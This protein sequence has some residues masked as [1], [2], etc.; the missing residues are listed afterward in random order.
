MRPTDL[1]T[2][3]EVVATQWLRRVGAALLRAARADLGDPDQRRAAS[4]L[5]ARAAPAGLHP[6]RPQRRARAGRD[7]HR[8]RAG[9]PAGGPRTGRTG[10]G[11]PGPGGTGW[12]SRSPRW[13]RCAT[14]WTPASAAAASRCGGAASP[15][16]RTWPPP[17]AA[18]APP[19]CRPPCAARWTRLQQADRP[20]GARLARGEALV[21]DAER[22]VDPGPQVLH[23]DRVG[24]LHQPA[25]P[26][27]G[28]QLGDHLVGDRRRLGG[29]RVGV[30][31]RPAL[32]RG[33][34]R[35]RRVVVQ[36]PAA[37]RRRA[38]DGRAASCRSRRTTST[39]P[40]TRRGRPRARAGWPAGC[41]SRA[42][43][44]APT[45]HRPAAPAGGARGPGPVPGPLR[46]DAGSGGNPKSSQQP[47]VPGGHQWQAWHV[48]FLWPAVSW[49]A[50]RR[51]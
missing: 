34:R 7:R 30:G 25:M 14:G 36:R 21:G 18:P 48:I 23:A 11:C 46:T 47:G 32:G 16:R 40:G 8:A 29:H 26:E 49:L 33:E 4:V 24:Q 42:R 1:L 35:R 41:A 39:R 38:L 45:R 19:T 50:E 20:A 10:P 28:V 51:D 44:A 12:T 15:T 13:R 31:Q 17:G 27:L 2:V 3:G 22:G 9:C 37:G 6:G 43:S 5:P